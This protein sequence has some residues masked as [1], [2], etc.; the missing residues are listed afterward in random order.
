MLS[1]RGERLQMRLS[2][3]NQR[4]SV[5]S[6]EAWGEHGG[7]ESKVKRGGKCG[8][9][10]RCGGGSSRWWCSVERDAWRDGVHGRGGTKRGGWREREWDTHTHTHT[11]HYYNN[12][13][14]RPRYRF[15]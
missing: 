12:H 11:C 7:A 8:G 14:N 9:G 5:A 4:G 2:S 3:G 13:Y 15:A 1:I 10:W 6:R